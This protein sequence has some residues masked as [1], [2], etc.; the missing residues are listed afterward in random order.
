[1]NYPRGTKKIEFVPILWYGAGMFRVSAELSYNVV[2]ATRQYIDPF[3]QKY[4]KM[5]VKRFF[6]CVDW[7]FNAYCAVLKLIC[8][9]DIIFTICI[10]DYS[11]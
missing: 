2:Q 5:R 10:Y 1:M 6:K 7:F 3:M 11:L 8:N 9:C 4:S